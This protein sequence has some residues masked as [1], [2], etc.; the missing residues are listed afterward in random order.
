[1]CAMI[2]LKK[3]A[4]GKENAATYILSLNAVTVLFCAIVGI[5]KDSAFLLPYYLPELLP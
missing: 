2:G 3:G 4:E 1:M 5:Q